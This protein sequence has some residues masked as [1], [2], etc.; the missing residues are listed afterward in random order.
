M[1]K[2]KDVGLSVPQLIMATMLVVGGVGTYYI[3]PTA[4]LYKNYTLFFFIMN[5]LLLTMIIGLTFIAILLLP[6]LQKIVLSCMLFFVKRD[7]K[8]K[9]LI[10]K[11]MKS[12]SSRNTKTAIMF[13]ICLSF[14][15]FSGS[16]F[17]LLGNLIVS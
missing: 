8:L 12:H 2:L 14:L 13:A 11:N 9:F 17:S 5:I 10:V 16:T 6:T 1:K 3:A 15:I 7:W 4:F